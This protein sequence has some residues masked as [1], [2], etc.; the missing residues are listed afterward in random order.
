MRVGIATDHNG[1]DQKANIL[2]FL[3]EQNI[4][5][6]DLYEGDKIPE[7]KKSIIRSFLYSLNRGGR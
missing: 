3:G 5:V 4:E 7:G 1:V 6:F 2:F